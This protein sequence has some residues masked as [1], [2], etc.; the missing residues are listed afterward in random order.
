[1]REKCGGYKGNSLYIFPISVVLLLMAKAF[2]FHNH[3]ILDFFFFFSI[4]F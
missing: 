4:D 3:N 1:M 2:L